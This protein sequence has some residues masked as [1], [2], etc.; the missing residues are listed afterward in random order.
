MIDGVWARGGVSGD[1]SGNYFLNIV[2][3]GQAISGRACRIS[4]TEIIFRDAPVRGEYPL[5]EFVVAAGTVHP[6]CQHLVGVPFAGRVTRDETIVGDFGPANGVTTAITFR[7]FSA[8]A[9]AGCFT[10][11]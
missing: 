6:C 5:L 9:P 10:Q 8:G 7:R 3:D 2:T 4:G 1:H 11:N